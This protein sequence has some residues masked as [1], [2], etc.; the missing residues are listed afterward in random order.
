MT[1]AQWGHHRRFFSCLQDEGLCSNPTHSSVFCVC[2]N[3]HQLGGG[4][5]ELYVP[6]V[7]LAPSRDRSAQGNTNVH[8]FGSEGKGSF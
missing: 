8:P 1:P 7:D 2:A 6:P 3:G 5:T 4:V